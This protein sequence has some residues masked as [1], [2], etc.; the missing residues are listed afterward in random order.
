[1]SPKVTRHIN[2]PNVISGTT[3]V[4]LV[5]TVAYVVVT[6]KLPGAP[7]EDQAVASQASKQAQTTTIQAPP[8]S[9]YVTEDRF[10]SRMD[11]L[12]KVINTRFDSFEKQLDRVDGTVQRHIEQSTGR[13]R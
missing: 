1:M 8:G 10:N 13:V 12:E 5:A 6:G 4:T 9:S 7:T 11:A 3:L 2:P